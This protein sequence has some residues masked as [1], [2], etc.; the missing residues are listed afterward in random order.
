[1]RDRAVAKTRDFIFLVELN[2]AGNVQNATWHE[3]GTAKFS[4]LEV[5]VS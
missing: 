2:S 5:E 1:M 4:K 3:A